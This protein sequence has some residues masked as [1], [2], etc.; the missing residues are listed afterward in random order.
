MNYVK[1]F[2]ALTALLTQ[3]YCITIEGYPVEYL[4]DVARLAA[5]NN[6]TP[7]NA[8]KQIA[9][10]KTMARVLSEDMKKTLEDVLRRAI[11]TQ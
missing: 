5:A 11:C 9:D 4:T 3:R 1:V 6:I 2:H 10:I 8:I 7:E